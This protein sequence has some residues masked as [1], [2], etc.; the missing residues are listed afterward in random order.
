M[1]KGGY[2]YIVT[3]K[4]RTTLY[5]GVTSSLTGRTYEHKEHKYK[6]SF[7]GKYNAEY[8]VYYEIFDSIEAAIE[9]EK[10]LKKWNRKKKEALINTINPEWRDLYNDVLRELM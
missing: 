2:I 7:T 10:Q 5:I 9:R 1:F 4:H 8:L 3:N 6:N